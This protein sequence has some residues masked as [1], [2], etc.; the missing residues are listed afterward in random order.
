MSLHPSK[1][2][3]VV[4]LENSLI[5]FF[6]ASFA[7]KKIP[8]TISSCRSHIKMSILEKTGGEVDIFNIFDFKQFNKF[9]L[10]ELFEVF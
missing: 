7:K 4:Q 3:D 8:A 5:E 1:N 9:K 10:F 6:K 2:G